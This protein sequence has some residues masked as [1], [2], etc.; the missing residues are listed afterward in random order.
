MATK[1][2][3]PFNKPGLNM[4]NVNEG[5]ISA[6]MDFQAAG[7]PAKGATALNISGKLSVKAATGTKQFTIEN[8]DIKTNVS[9][10]CGDLPLKISAAGLG[11]GMFSNKEEFSVTFS[12]SQDLDSLSTLEFSDAQGGKIEARKSSWGGGMGEYF[13]EFVFQKNPDHAKIVA[14][15]WQNMKT[16][17]V[18]ISIKTG[19]GL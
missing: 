6:N 13:V 16:V 9:F 15:C 19:M 3:D 1:S 14:T 7:L 12:S 11:K 5:G 18:P 2:E 10:T 17:E 4:I 8:V